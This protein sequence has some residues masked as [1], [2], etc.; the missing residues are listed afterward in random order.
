MNPLKTPAGTLP[1]SPLAN[2]TV[3]ITTTANLPPA[4]KRRDPWTPYLPW[5]TATALAGLMAMFFASRHK[6]VPAP[7]RWAYLSLALLVVGGL[8]GC[9]TMKLSTPKGPAAKAVTVTATSGSV[10]KMVTID[11]NVK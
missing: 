1:G 5:A 8:V 10:V 3:T 4:P 6:I 11:V 7:G 2:P 9:T